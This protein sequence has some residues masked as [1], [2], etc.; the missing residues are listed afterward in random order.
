MTGIDNVAESQLDIDGDFVGGRDHADQDAY[1]NALY[2][3]SDGYN[4]Q[5]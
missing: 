1:G 3:D 5:D 2:S 4:S